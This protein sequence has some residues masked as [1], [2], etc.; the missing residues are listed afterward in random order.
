MV[1]LTEF[2]QDN[3]ERLLYDGKTVALF[4]WNLMVFGSVNLTL[5]DYF[6]FFLKSI[7]F[8]NESLVDELFNIKSR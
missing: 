2:Q 8:I 4:C 5:S 3:Y 1:I 7:H 6:F